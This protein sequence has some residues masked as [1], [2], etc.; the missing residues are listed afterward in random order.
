MQYGYK[1]TQN[2]ILI[3]NPLKKLQKTHE[4]KVQGKSGIK[5]SFGLYFYFYFYFNYCE[6]KFSDSNTLMYRQPTWIHPD[7]RS[8]FS[9]RKPPRT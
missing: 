9:S 2:L 4:K 6:Q 1:K 8:H 7:S 3:L 5:M